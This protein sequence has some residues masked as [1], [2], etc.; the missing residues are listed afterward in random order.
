[1]VYFLNQ[2]STIN[3]TNLENRIEVMIVN[4]KTK[5]KPKTILGR[6]RNLV[7]DFILYFLTV[8]II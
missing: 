3:L 5:Q 7:F 1:M 8:Y 6:I 2:C 4:S